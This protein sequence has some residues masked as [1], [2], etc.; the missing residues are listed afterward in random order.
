M[1]IKKLKNIDIADVITLIFLIQLLC[2]IALP[3]LCVKY[4]QWFSAD[5]YHLYDVTHW[6][7]IPEYEEI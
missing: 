7:S 1:I 3:L 6:M 5:N 2:I 4:H